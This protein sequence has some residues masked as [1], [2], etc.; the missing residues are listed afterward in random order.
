MGGLFLMLIA[1]L[2]AVAKKFA[3]GQQTPNA[4][5][6]DQHGPRR[7]ADA[8]RDPHAEVEKYNAK[9]CECEVKKPQTY[10]C[11]QAPNQYFFGGFVH[12]AKF[13]P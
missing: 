13:C 3:G 6:R 8:E 1:R 11:P 9:M 10:L 2:P 4:A 7:S 5:A 12:L